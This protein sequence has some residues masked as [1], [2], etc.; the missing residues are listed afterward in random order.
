MKA[1]EN[2]YA[3]FLEIKAAYD[4]AEAAKDEAGQNK[5]RADYKVWT[6]GIEAK[7]R[8]YADTFRIYKDSR[9]NGNERFDIS[10]P[11]HVRNIPELVQN[12]K[13]NGI[14]EFTYSSTWSSAIE[15]SWEFLQNGCEIAGM[16]EVFTH[17][18]K[19]FSDEHETTP[20]YIFRLK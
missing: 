4:R 20:A 13:E 7:G 12:L 8:A 6:E 3:A 18:T 10:E 19:M 16:T 2:D 1:F 9:D 17:C 5:A 14:T 15:A 11:H